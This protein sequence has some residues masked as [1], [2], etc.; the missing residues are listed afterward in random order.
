[1]VRWLG[2]RLVMA[3]KTALVLSVRGPDATWDGIRTAWFQDLV[4]VKFSLWPL[5][6]AAVLQTPWARPSRTTDQVPRRVVGSDW[7]QLSVARGARPQ[8]RLEAQRDSRYAVR[9]M[10]GPSPCRS[11]ILSLVRH[12]RRVRAGPDSD[13]LLEAL[14]KAIGFQYRIERLLGRGRDGRGVPRSRARAGSRRCDQGPA[15][16]AGRHPAGA[17]TL[18]PRGADRST[19]ESPGTSVPL[20]TFGEVSGLVYFVMGYVAGES[21]ASRLKREGALPSEEARRISV[22]LCEALEYA[23]QRG[24]VHR[25]I[26]PD[27]ILIETGSG[28]PL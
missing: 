6:F 22:A 27:N 17:R 11:A 18:P 13:P 7:Q 15:S 1:M 21:L 10:R 4:L 23:H 9:C 2:Y 28:T 20:H 25:D 8:V 3:A 12:A 5:A 26:K 19:P 16:R 14:T 24:I